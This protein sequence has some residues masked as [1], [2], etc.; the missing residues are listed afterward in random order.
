MQSQFHPKCWV[1]L[2]RSEATRALLDLKA[3]MGNDLNL[4]NKLPEGVG[5]QLPLSLP[6]ARLFLG[7]SELEEL[8]RGMLWHRLT[9]MQ[10]MSHIPSR[11]E[12]YSQVCNL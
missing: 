6:P 1:I 5:R 7:F 10:R 12:F 8:I 2:D 4:I 3:G 9:S 11:Y